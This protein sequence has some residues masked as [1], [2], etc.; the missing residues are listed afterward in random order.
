MINSSMEV[1]VS[2]DTDDVDLSEDAMGEVNPI[3]ID[4]EDEERLRVSPSRKSRLSAS[5]LISVSSLPDSVLPQD[6]DVSIAPSITS[7]MKPHISKSVEDLLI[8]ADLENCR[9]RLSRHGY[10]SMRSLRLASKEDLVEI[11]LPRGHAG[12]LVYA[13]AQE[14]KGHGPG[15][16]LTQIETRKLEDQVLTPKV[17]TSSEAIS[18]MSEK[19]DY[20]VVPGGGAN[21]V[22]K[23]LGVKDPKAAAPDREGWGKKLDFLLVCIGYAVGLGNIWRFPYL[24]YTHGGG[25]FLIPYFLML[26]LAGMPLMF[27]ELAFGQYGGEGPITIWKACPLFAGESMQCEISWHTEDQWWVKCLTSDRREWRAFVAALHARR[28]NGHNYVLGVDGHNLDD[29]GAMKWEL[30]VCLLFSWIVIFCCICKSVKSSGKVV[31]F[32]ATFPYVILTILLIR[33]VTLPGAEIGINYYLSPRWEKLKETQVWGAAAT[34]IFYS[35]GPA[36][37]GVL[38]F[39]SY[40]KFNNNCLVDAICIP[41]INC[42]SSFYAGF[43]VFSTLGFM[44]YKTGISIDNVAVRGPG[45]VFETYP[46]AISQMPVAP[47]WAILFFFMF[48]LVGLD[49]QFGMVETVVSGLVDYFPNHL[50]KHGTL[51][52]LAVCVFFFLLGLPMASQGGI[53]M[54][55]LINWYS[56]WISLMLVG[57]FECLAVV[58]FYGVRRFMGDI[59]RMVAEYTWMQ[60]VLTPL[61]YWYSSC[62]LVITPAIILFITV[63]G[64]INYVPV[65]FGD[66][67]YPKWSEVL[68]WLMAVVPLLTIP[69]VM[70]IKLCF[71]SEGDNY[72]QRFLFLLKPTRDWENKEKRFQAKTHLP[73]AY[74]KDVELDSLKTNGMY[75]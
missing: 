45:L 50:R 38:T 74:E 6:P 62:W 34:Q 11:G 12:L 1:V 66:Y 61:L 49:T 60:P 64:M 56:C 51:V 7:S 22:G 53:Y 23:D 59:R 39:S 13:I 41:L 71:A 47:L 32:T 44:S 15:K 58:Y 40:N 43:V 73:L 70:V 27:L 25:V 67:V 52:A 46:E 19:G 37:G 29:M 54:F 20:K 35:L 26:F 69:L 48:F 10:D 68:G 65:Y 28:H 21:D 8:S 55:E 18:A 42:L 9:N 33:G 17:L 4:I 5:D 2:T 3:P 30:V 57:C 63:F 31:Y 36:W 75:A 72:A 16:G 14:D 24:C